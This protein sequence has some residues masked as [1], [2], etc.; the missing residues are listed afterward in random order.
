MWWIKEIHPSNT[1][2]H[3][4]LRM[5]SGHLHL[6]HETLRKHLALP[7]KPRLTV[8]GPLVAANRG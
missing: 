1:G 8:A 6:A 4:S 7:C 5:L 2:E 3:W